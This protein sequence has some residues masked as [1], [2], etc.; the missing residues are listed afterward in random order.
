VTLRA[1]TELTPALHAEVSSLVSPAFGLTSLP[2]TDIHILL[3]QGGETAGYCALVRRV[4]SMDGSP[5]PVHLLGLLTIDGSLR[6]RGMG[7]RLLGFVQ[8]TA[9]GLDG[10]GIILNCGNDISRFYEKNGFRRIAESAL[11]IRGSRT[12]RDADPVY[13]HGRELPAESFGD[14]I[15]GEDF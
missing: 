13:F 4:V 10:Q 15:L 14:I 7:S 11:Y 9:A 5:V 6:G 3:T 12:E 2:R 8:D 1:L